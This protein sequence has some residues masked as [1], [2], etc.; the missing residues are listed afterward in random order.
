M[1]KTVRQREKEDYLGTM[2]AMKRKD[3]QII[4]AEIARELGVSAA[5]VDRLSREL[6][7]EGYLQRD[8]SR[9]LFLTPFGLSKGQEWM[10]RKRCLT[11]FLCLVSGVDRSLAQ[12]NACAIEHILD[13]RV[14]M[15]IR[16]FME[17]RHTYSYTMRESDL[18]L[19]F[20]EGK[21]EFPA[22]FFEKGT[23][24]PRIL[25][26]EY[27]DFEK[28]AK[29][30]IC[31]ESFLYLCPAAEKTEIR[32][33]EYSEKDRWERAVREKNGF[34]VPA[35]ALHCI[36]RQSGRISEG[37]VPIRTLKENGQWHECILAVSL[38]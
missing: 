11:E 24:H 27:W 25:S 8:G 21:R 1:T 23:S 38:I 16:M 10:E 18:N 6:T 29:A 37:T 31:R 12:E 20:P 7:E 9:G 34:A 15:G 3:H 19:M 26:E 14:L 35:R 5:K 4:K 28:K 22:A 32:A 30:V 13:E 2:Y 33:L 17:S 36:L